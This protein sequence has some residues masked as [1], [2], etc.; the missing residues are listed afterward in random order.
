MTK[1]QKKN[2]YRII[3]S[4]VLLLVLKFAADPLIGKLDVNA[5]IRKLIEIA[6]Y[7]IP[8]LIVGGNVVAKAGR[9]MLHG[10][11]FDENFL[12][13]VATIG[14]FALG[15]YTEAA[16]VMIFYQVGT[17]FE[18]I[19][20]AR[21]RKSIASLAALRP[22]YVN[23]ER[24]G[25]LVKL[26][27]EGVG[28]GDTIIVLAGEKVPL[29]GEVIDGESYVDTSALTGESVPRRV[30][31]GSEIMSG[32]INQQGKLVVRVSKE[33]G[34]ST[35]CKILDMVQ[36]AS[37][38]KSRSENFITRFARIYTPAVVGAAVLVAVLPPVITGQAFSKWI[39]RALLFLVVSC[40]CALVISIP[41]GFFGGIGAASKCGI[42][43]KGSN[44]LEALANAGTIV[45]DK[46]GTLT[47]GVFRVQEIVGAKRVCQAVTD[48]ADTT[49]AS[50][51]GSD[52]K[53]EHV[54]AFGTTERDRILEVA[55]YAEAY[56]NHPIG[57][58]I[59]LYYEQQ[60]HSVDKSLIRDTKEVSGKGIVLT[61]DS[62]TFYVGN[63]KLL[64]E[65]GIVE[66]EKEEP[67][68]SAAMQCKDG[69]VVYVADSERL[70]GYIVISDEI[71]DN[72][73]E[74][75]EQLSAQGI[76][77][78]VMLTGDRR[79]TAEAVAEKLGISKTYSELLPQDKLS[80]LEEIIAEGTTPTVFV[81][82]GI[83]DAPALT[84]ADVGI[85]MGG[86]GQDAA[87]EAADIVL[88]DDNPGK[89]VIARKIGIKTLAIVKQNIVFAL[90]VKLL[91][92]VLGV[93]GIAN[94]WMAVF[95]DVG[96]SVI[97]ILNSMRLLNHKKY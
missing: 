78:S 95:G 8:Y 72:T 66:E 89:I 30:S 19:A 46:T 23:V 18:S 88:M 49:H 20:V 79:A 91:I 76:A 60:G 36:N 97:A 87:I 37:S 41:L 47:K 67:I 15:D 90:A 62:G 3:I 94:M 86:L 59:E 34:E 74:A 22:D 81:G 13:T 10:H 58:S 35:V 5:E 26:S 82:D 48:D 42:L 93:I 53:G 29:D 92:M 50:T 9:N 64:Q 31:V 57:R 12:M 39:E 6:V 96:V 1:K 55:A 73:T 65:A 21:S 61:K 54:E 25:E 70:L 75:I 44:Y 24:D 52:I 63:A 85:A 16:A 32:Y 77:E 7:L 51:V 17:L 71:K 80:I 38:R 45:F 33:F 4:L 2:L 43:I 27:P 28:I 56:S 68:L 84:R 11:I 40:P 83:N 14:A 69:T